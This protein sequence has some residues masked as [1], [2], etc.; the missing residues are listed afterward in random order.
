M[1]NKEAKKLILAAER[2]YL[3][4]GGRLLGGRLAGVPALL[5][6]GLGLGLNLRGRFRFGL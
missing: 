2:E 3:Y 6:L 1:T 4:L 5:R